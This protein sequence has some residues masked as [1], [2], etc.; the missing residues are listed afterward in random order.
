[1]LQSLKDSKQKHLDGVYERN[2]LNDLMT[3]AEKR[4]LQLDAEVC[5]S[6]VFLNNLKCSTKTCFFISWTTD[7]NDNKVTMAMIANPHRNYQLVLIHSAQIK[8]FFYVE[9][10]FISH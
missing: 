2:Q 10:D 9:R 3:K 6:L 8:S 5:F 4:L 7:L 1:M